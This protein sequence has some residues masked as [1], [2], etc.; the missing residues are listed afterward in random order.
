MFYSQGNF[1]TPASLSHRHIAVD[2][3]GGTGEHFAGRVANSDSQ[4]SHLRAD[5]SKCRDDLRITGR[6]P[7][8]QSDIGR[9]FGRR[10][11]RFLHADRTQHL[12]RGTL[13]QQRRQALPMQSH[14]ADDKYPDM[15]RCRQVL[16]HLSTDRLGTRKVPCVPSYFG[17]GQN[18]HAVSVNNNAC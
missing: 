2:A 8:N 4:D 9:H 11:L 3:G 12:N 1:F 14:I 15:R 6:Q 17:V 5:F 10:V 18:R 7:I 13:A 16:V